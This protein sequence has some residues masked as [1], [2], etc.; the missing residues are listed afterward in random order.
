MKI[1]TTLF[2]S[3]VT[4]MLFAQE[5]D[6]NN[7]IKWM[8]W[9][10]AVEANKVEQ[11]K[12][13]VDVYT[14]WCHWCKEMDKSTFKDAE[15]IKLLN[16]KFYAVKFNAEQKEN[17]EFDNHTFGYRQSG[18]RGAH[19]LAMALLDNNMGYPSFVFLDESFQRIMLS[20]GFKKPPKL[21]KELT[22]TSNEAYKHTKWDDFQ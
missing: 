9:E 19:E 21:I 8:S 15:V 13:F 4:I 10:E 7:K 2:L 20:P 14:N 12:I 18:R 22:Y 6:Q 11:K 5:A 3:M 17:I 1:Y 16:E